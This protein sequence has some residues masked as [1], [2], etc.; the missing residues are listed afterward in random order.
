MEQM[1]SILEKIIITKRSKSKSVLL[2]LGLFALLI[3]LSLL[4][5]NWYLQQII[6]T[7]KI[8]GNTVLSTG[9]INSIID[10]EIMNVPKSGIDLTE[11]KNKLISNEYIADAFV[12]C[13]SKGVIGIEIKER[14]PLA[15]VVV[16]EDI[17]F[18][19]QTGTTFNYRLYKEYGDLP[20]ISNVNKS[21]SDKMDKVALLGAIAIVTELQNSPSTLNKLISEV[22]FNR[23]NGAYEL[24]LSDSNINVLFGKPD[25]IIEKL[26][27]IYSFWK[28]KILNSSEKD[29]FKNIDAR[30][31]NTIIVK[32]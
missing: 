23:D 19:D 6:R 1:D 29:I 9:E 32:K 17:M 5:S 30:W 4:S 13:N 2:L 26:N 3:F 12:W 15:V 14:V 31:K 24:F 22:H 11:I 8:S 27:N 28:E 21:F 10:N 25:N 7:V 16:N 18:V 20:I